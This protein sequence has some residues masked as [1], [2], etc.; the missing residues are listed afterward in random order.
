M[1]G[2]DDAGEGAE[3]GVSS[4]RFVEN[5]DRVDHRLAGVALGAE[6]GGDAH[7]GEHPGHAGTH[8]VR[9]DDLDLM[10]TQEARDAGV[11]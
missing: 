7:R 1:P 5:G 2:G 6:H 10:L 4:A 3:S 11:V 9:D 8:V